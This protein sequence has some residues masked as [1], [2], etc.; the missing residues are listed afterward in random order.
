MTWDT[1]LK[2]RPSDPTPRAIV[3][4]RALSV[5]GVPSEEPPLRLRA[6]ITPIGRAVGDEGIA[7]SADPRVSR[8]HAVI[9]LDGRSHEVRLLDRSSTG[10]E[11]NGTPITQAVL[12]D[13]DLV[14]V[15]DSALLVRIGP[16][17]EDGAQQPIGGLL[18]DAPVMRRLRRT[19]ARV[20]RSN[21]CV[22][23]LGES[24]TGKELAARALHEISGR[25]GELVSVNCSAI[26]T[27][28][29]EA[30]LFGHLAGS[31]TGARTPSPGVFRAADG[32]TLFLDEVAD[33][34][35]EVQPKM[36]RVL[37]E[38]AVAPVGATR[39][40]PVDVRVVAASNR[41]LLGE[42]E[43][44]R[45]RGDLY[46]RLSDFTV[47][48]PPLRDRRED[49][50]PLFVRELGPGAPALAPE[51]V[52]A[53]LLHSW[54]FNV[55][56]LVKVARQLRIDGAGKPTLDLSLLGDRLARTA[57]AATAGGSLGVVD[58]T[59]RSSVRASAPAPAS[60]PPSDPA[61]PTRAHSSARDGAAPASRDKDLLEQL[62]REHKGVIADVARA[63]GRS[64]K[65]VY[66][67]LLQ[68]GLDAGAYRSD[69]DR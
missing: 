6:G 50:L 40:T 14:V 34:P 28:L 30:Q 49:I 43:A 5:A 53:L 3:S 57:A 51:L 58:G 59:S 46:A 52:R 10:T 33:L 42:V 36:L 45:F 62:L 66:R 7:L 37:E 64:R 65:Q 60:P 18:G 17:D 8:L 38:R 44:G 1:T 24:G 23:L 55:R 47:E 22:L 15:G 12:A 67:W 11:V 25:Q 48:L 61:P 54:P 68:H 29:A 41:D 4:V 9:E 69:D 21:S 31:Y 20:G 19:L 63:T 56:E 32:G 13:G 27:E 2:V 16:A 39:A 35:I 26:P